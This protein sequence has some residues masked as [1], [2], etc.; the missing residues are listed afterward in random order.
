MLQVYA[1]LLSSK[2]FKATPPVAL[3]PRLDE[4]D[5]EAGQPENTRKS[6]LC[7]KPDYSAL[8]VANENG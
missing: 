1:F 5:K 6:D 8:A 3:K 7:W 4:I 2:A